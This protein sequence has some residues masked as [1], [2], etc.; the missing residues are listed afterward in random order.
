M[1]NKKFN[2]FSQS[3]KIQNVISLKIKVVFVNK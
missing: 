3:H 2:H 1:L